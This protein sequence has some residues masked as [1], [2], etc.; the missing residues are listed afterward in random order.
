M[1]LLPQVPSVVE[2]RVAELCRDLAVQ[3]K[4]MR[5]LQEEADELRMAI[6]EWAREFDT[7]TQPESSPRPGRR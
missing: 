4:R 3:A 6:G 2:G 5:E 1:R 7:D